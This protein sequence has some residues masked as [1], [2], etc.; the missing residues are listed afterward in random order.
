MCGKRLA[1]LHIYT[2]RHNR[3]RS[4]QTLDEFQDR[5]LVACC[6]ADLLIEVRRSGVD[7]RVQKLFEEF[8]LY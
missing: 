8:R 4:S 6:W 5:D 3:E 1:F 7:L 2:Q